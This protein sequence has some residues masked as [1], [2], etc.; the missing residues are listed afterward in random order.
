MDYITSWAQSLIV[1]EILRLAVK[2]AGYDALA[3]GNPES[4]K[5]VETQ[6]FHKLKNYDVEGLQGPVSYTPGD[7]RLTKY[8]R[9]YQIVN[10]QI[11]NPS[12]W[13]EAPLVEYEKYEWFGK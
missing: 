12:K 8:N 1:A 7:N 3:K 5:I 2:N 9:I 13:V 4:W 11:A 10:G 6:G